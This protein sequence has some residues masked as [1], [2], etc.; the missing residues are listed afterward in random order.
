M[1][2]C[3]YVY[4]YG[5]CLCFSICCLL[6][7]FD[8]NI[9]QITLSFAK[10]ISNHMMSFMLFIR[11]EEWIFLQEASHCHCYCTNMQHCSIPRAGLVL[12]TLFPI[13]LWLHETTFPREFHLLS[14]FAKWPSAQGAIW[15]PEKTSLQGRAM[16]VFPPQAWQ[17]ASPWVS[18]EILIVFSLF[19][20]A[21]HEFLPPLSLLSQKLPQ[22]QSLHYGR[23]KWAGSRSPLMFHRLPGEDWN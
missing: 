11:F 17:L 2:V 23:G 22:R 4:K 7:T 10:I 20:K 3:V 16:A 1:N 8:T 15:A 18:G 12:R 6:P 13:Q 9:R 5:S 21:L 19:N 14:W